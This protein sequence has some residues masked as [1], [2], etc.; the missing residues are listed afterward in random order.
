MKSQP[1]LSRDN[2]VHFESDC[3]VNSRQLRVF[4]ITFPTNRTTATNFRKSFVLESYEDYK[5]EKHISIVFSSLF[6]DFFFL[7]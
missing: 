5:G 7:S 2:T 3:E 4:W 1:T 6:L